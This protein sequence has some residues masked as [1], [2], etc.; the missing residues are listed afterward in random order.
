MIVEDVIDGVSI[1]YLDYGCEWMSECGALFCEIFCA[2]RRSDVQG[3]Q[4]GDGCPQDETGD[5]DGEERARRV[6]DE[7]SIVARQAR[8]RHG[9]RLAKKLSHFW[10]QLFGRADAGSDLSSSKANYGI[11]RMPP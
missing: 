10:R 3:L 7:C 2:Q 8:T 9:S 6:F 11:L 4:Y 1:I 5:G